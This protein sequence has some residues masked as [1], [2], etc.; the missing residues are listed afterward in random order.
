MK[1]PGSQQD[2][3]AQMNSLETCA[4]IFKM[5][6]N[7]KNTFKSRVFQKRERQVRLALKKKEFTNI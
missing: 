6:V 2:L 7:Q 4:N 5:E 1:S 3:W